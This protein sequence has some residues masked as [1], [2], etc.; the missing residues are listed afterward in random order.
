LISLIFIG[1]GQTLGRAFNA[2]SSPIEAYS[3]NLLGSLAGIGG[4]ALLAYLRTSPPVWFAVIACLILYF[5]TRTGIQRKPVTRFASVAAAALLVGGLSLTAEM[6]EPGNRMKPVTIWSPYYKIHFEPSTRQVYVNNIQHQA[7]DDLTQTGAFYRVPHLMNRDTGAPPFE[8]VLIIG[9]GTGNDVA[10]ALAH[11]AKHVDAVE[12]DP[13]LYEIGRQYHPN[14]H[15]VDPRVSPHIDDGRSFVRSTRKKYDLVVYALVDSL[16]LHSGYSSLRLESFLFT[17]QAFRDVKDRLKPGG[18]FVVYNYYR[19][20]WVVGRLTKLLERVFGTEPIVLSLPYQATVTPSDNQGNRLNFLLAGTDQ[21]A[22]LRAIRAFLSEFHFYWVHPKASANGMVNAYLPIPPIVPGTAQSEW[23]KLGPAHVQTEGIG[24]L[25]TDDFPY[26]YL[27]EAVIPGLNLRG[28][29]IVVVLSLAVLFAFAPVRTVRP[30]GQMF[31][32]GAGFMLLETKGVVHLALLFGS[33]WM[34]NSI[35]FAAILVMALLG[36]LYVLA[37]KPRRLWPYYVALVAA[38]LLNLAVPMTSFLALPG[39]SRIIVSCLVVFVP[40]LFAGVVFAASFRVSRQPDLDFGS[41]IGG[42]IL[43]G[44]SENLSLLLGFNN[45]LIVAIVYY[46][47][48][49]IFAPRLGE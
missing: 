42:V 17:E 6:L 22:A 44:L 47:L 18:V 35:V 32:L 25:P 12:I 19:Q 40:V 7:M 16:V 11:G 13:V 29:A 15:G 10:T 37:V 46:V 1:I 34:V 48:S 43:G 27:R 23:Y 49:A 14:H 24:T 3:I 36:N 5:L 20:G 8:E 9:A 41:N 38:L 31:F 21:S 4:F 30:N 33:T 26:L 28:M 45:L 2:I 39:A